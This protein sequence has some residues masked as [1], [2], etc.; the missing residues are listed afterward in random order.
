ML[1]HQKMKSIIMILFSIVWVSVHAQ[2]IGG[3]GCGDKVQ[4]TSS[5]GLNGI[6][7]TE[8]FRGGSGRGDQRLKTDAI[9]LHGS[10]Y[11]FQ[12][13]GGSGNGEHSFIQTSTSLAG[14]DFQGISRGG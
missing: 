2:Y 13:S 3:N 6:F 4:L 1:Y 8:L 10:L 9:G 11:N 12:Y 14:E 5:I 7:Y